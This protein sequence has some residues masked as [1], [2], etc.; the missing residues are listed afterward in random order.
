MDKRTLAIHE[1]LRLV[2]YESSGE[3]RIEDR[4]LACSGWLAPAEGGRDPCRSGPDGAYRIGE[5]GNNRRETS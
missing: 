5:H 2:L 4:G 1:N 3:A